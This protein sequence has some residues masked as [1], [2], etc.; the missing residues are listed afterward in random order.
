MLFYSV[1]HEASLAGRFVHSREQLGLLIVVVL[2][3]TA[4]PGQAIGYKVSFVRGGDSR[5]LLIDAVE[6]SN[7]RVVAQ[8]HM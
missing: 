3:N 1:A 4:V 5:S 7:E 8:G 6:S 2:L